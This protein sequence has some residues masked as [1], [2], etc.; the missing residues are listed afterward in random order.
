MLTSVLPSRSGLPTQR[1]T[2]VRARI[3]PAVRRPAR[4]REAFSPGRAGQPRPILDKEG[5]HHEDRPAAGPPGRGRAVHGHGAQKLFGWFGGPGPDGTEQMMY[6]I[7]MRPARRARRWRSN[8][9]GAWCGTRSTSRARGPQPRR[10][11]ARPSPAK[12]AAEISLLAATAPCPEGKPRSEHG[13]GPSKPRRAVFALA[14]R[15]R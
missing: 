3:A 14:L 2:C 4:G 10:R 12:P 6:K 8:W 13:A 11:P 9:A 7:D 5:T 15:P 1:G